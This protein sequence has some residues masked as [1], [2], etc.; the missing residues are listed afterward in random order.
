MKSQ[1]VT[2]SPHAAPSRVEGPRTLRELGLD[3]ALAAEL[4]LAFRL[5]G[6]V[7]GERVVGH[8]FT[9]PDGRRHALRVAQDAARAAVSR[10]A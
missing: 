9:T 4:E 8:T 10:A 2:S 6:A 5:M 7:Q 1:L 3:G